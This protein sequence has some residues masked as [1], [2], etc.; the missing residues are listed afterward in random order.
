MKLNYKIFPVWLLLIFIQVYAQA[1]NEFTLQPGTVI[2]LAN[3]QRGKELI[4]TP[5]E[6]TA[7]LSKFDLQSKANR[8]EKILKDEVTLDDY[9][10]NAAN[11]VE[12]WTD[13]E[14]TSF[15]KVIKSVSDKISALGLNIKMPETIE[16]VKTTMKEEGGA[17]GYT[18]SNYIVLQD[19]MVSSTKV[20]DL[21]IHELFHVLSRFNP[22]MREK[23]YNA[24]GFH[25][26][27]EVDYPKEIHDK[28]IS[29]PDAPLN[30]YYITV[31]YFD[32]P[33]DVMMILYSNLPYK[34]GSFFK[35]L[36]IGLM[37]VEG[38]E[39]N[40]APVYK[41]GVP[42]IFEI[43]NVRNFYEQVGKNT[44]YIL[45]AEEISAE[46]FVMLLNQRRDLPNPELI[47]AMKKAM[48]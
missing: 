48:K 15:G 30:N 16:I 19:I 8:P 25:K 45:H 42:Y 32:Q 23:I 28:R 22:E 36:K 27:N 40:K 34:G 41:N 6:Y 14:K 12:D 3:L 20:E 39:N 11:Q 44:D 17:S 43:D 4:T 24:L 10:Q 2:R 26:C 5:D 29:N 33:V 37:A 46:H 31:N 7:V 21:L 38:P 1:Q 47:E 13:A 18:R 35:Y 9:L